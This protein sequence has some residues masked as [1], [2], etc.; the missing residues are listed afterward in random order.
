MTPFRLPTWSLIEQVIREPRGGW[1]VSDGS[2]VTSPLR[3]HSP[4]STAQRS[5]FCEDRTQALTVLSLAHSPPPTQ[6][7]RPL[8][9]MNV[10]VGSMIGVSQYDRCSQDD[11]CRRDDQCCQ[12][13]RVSQYDRCSQHDVSQLM[14]GSSRYRWI[15]RCSP[16]AL[17]FQSWLNIASLPFGS[18]QELSCGRKSSVKP[19]AGFRNVYAEHLAL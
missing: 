9:L 7:S 16:A 5:R 11:Q 3:L 8:Q 10:K 19:T 15:S 17:L 6:A 4:P 13:E 18:S 1:H 14:H 12:Y 2:A